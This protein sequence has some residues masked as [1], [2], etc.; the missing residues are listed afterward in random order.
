[1]EDVYMLTNGGPGSSTTFVGLHIYLEQYLE[2]KS[3]AMDLQCH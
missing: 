3:T 1:M 2:N